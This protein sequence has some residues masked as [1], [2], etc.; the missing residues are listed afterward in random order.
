LHQVGIL[1]HNQCKFF[2][3]VFVQDS[4]SSRANMYC[5]HPKNLY[6]WRNW[7]LSCLY[8]PWPCD[9]ML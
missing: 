7:M 4:L 5:I 9:V 8:R 2:N 6:F 1:I 3:F